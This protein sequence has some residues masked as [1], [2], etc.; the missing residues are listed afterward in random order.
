MNMSDTTDTIKQLTEPLLVNTTG[1]CVVGFSL[2]DTLVVVQILVGITL[3]FY[4]TIKIY[5]FFKNKSK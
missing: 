2:E 4:N 5:G 1:L 3:V